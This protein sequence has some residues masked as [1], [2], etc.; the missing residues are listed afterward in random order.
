VSDDARTGIKKKRHV[1]RWILLGIGIFLLTLV[2]L[3]TGAL[4]SEAVFRQVAQFARPLVPDELRYATVSGTLAGPVTFT[5]LEYRVADTRISADLLS[6]D[7]APFALLGSRVNLEDVYA[8]DLVVT[9]AAPAEEEPE[10]IPARPQDIIDALRLPVE[11]HADGIRVDEFV[12][13]KADGETLLQLQR[14]AA[15]LDWRDEYVEITSLETNGPQLEAAGSIRLGLVADE[16]S[17]VDLDAAWHGFAFPVRGHVTATGLPAQLDLNA[18]LAQ[19]AR[20]TLDARLQNL[21]DTP[22]WQGTLGVEELVPSQLRSD[23]PDESLAGTFRFAGDWQ[24]TNVQ[25]TAQGSWPPAEGIHLSFNADVNAMRT[26]VNEL[27]ATVKTYAAELS[28][29][30]ELHYADELR[31]VARGTVAHLAWPGVEGLALRD[32]RFDVNGDTQHIQGE[33]QALADGDAAGQLAV[34]GELQFANLKFDSDIKARDFRMTAGETRIAVHALVGRASGTPDDYQAEV[35][36]RVQVN[37]LPPTAATLHLAGDTQQLS[38]DLSSLQWLNGSATGNVRLD[39]QNGLSLAATL[40]GR[41]FELAAIDPQLSGTVGGNILATADFAAGQ[42]RIQVQIESLTGKVA[43]TELRGSGSI[44]LADGRINTQGLNLSAGDARLALEDSP[45]AGF[46]FALDVPALERFHPDLSGKIEANGHFEG[47]LAAPTVKLRVTGSDASWQEWETGRFDLDLDVGEGGRRQLSLQLEAHD[48]RTPYLDS[49]LAELNINGNLAAHAIAL[50][51]AGAGQDAAGEMQ[52]AVQGGLADGAWRG[53]IGRVQFNHPATGRW[54]L[55]ERAERAITLA[56]ERI[57][58]PALCL[59]GAEGYACLGPFTHDTGG[60]R[61]ES[62]LEKIPVG[63]IAGLLPAGLEYDG[64]VGG[65][66][67]ISGSD[68]GL[69][70][71][72]EIKLTAGGIRQ[73]AGAGSETLLGWQSGRA[74]VNLDGRVVRGKLNVDLEG[75][76]SITGSAR[77]D[78]PESGAMTVNAGVRASLD[79]LQLVPSLVPELSRVQGRITA[80]LDING[81]LDAPRIVGVARLHDA[82]ARI[83]TLGTTWQNVNLTLTGEG[84]EISL[85]GRA[86]SGDGHIE[87]DLEGRDTG[88]GFTGKARLSGTN[89]RAVNTPEAKVNISPQLHVTLQ[90]RELHVDGDVF[91]PFARIEPR[92][93]ATAVQPSEDQVIV[94]ADDQAGT[95]GLLVHAAVTTRLGE[96]VRLNAFGLK[97]RLEGKLTVSKA[98]Q[99]RA[100]GNGRLTIVE[101]EYQAYGQDLTLAKGDII[102]AGQSLDNPGLDIR[103]ERTIDPDIVAGVSVRGPLSQPAVSVYSDP[104]MP[105]TEAL[106]YLLFGRSMDQVTGEQAGQVSNASLALNLGGQ[107][108]LG[109]VG[110]KLGVEEMRVEQVGDRDQASLVLGKYLSPDL[111]V[112]YGI[113]LYEAVSTFRVRYRLSSKWTLEAASGLKSSADFLYTIER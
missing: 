17:H 28:A 47:D 100:T 22:R 27:A 98:P 54:Q 91:V 12:L 7:I 85:T 86:E 74:T 37:E 38:A 46:D 109:N 57:D 10:Q 70:G 30:G 8:R 53:G 3:V 79:N 48:L 18:R 66:F 60:W 103:A 113:G 21:L 84:R 61:A 19:P 78:V 112:S 73:A 34:N 81:P 67:A 40:R 2:L 80:D 55:R 68:A 6:F 35:D 71:R 89:F 99:Q 108:L 69:D 88:K 94:N 51:T 107:K 93:L 110:R 64:T 63:A 59:E 39:W 15:S 83:L 105:E 1:L 23:L 33:V 45:G 111:Y 76:D 87:V 4:Y 25:G 62:R 24:D 36:T 90:G 42:P 101:G 104:G 41:D 106:S 43:G 31:Y 65:Q 97:A 13:Q 9:L 44:R 56:A 29:D 58:V 32:A 16:S 11:I 95:E 26:R 52:I 49:Q 102:Y 75:G 82:N 20:A 14:F 92:D 77:L 96:D 50:S 72:G 5:G